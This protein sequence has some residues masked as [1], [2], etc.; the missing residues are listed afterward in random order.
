MKVTENKI[1][2]NKAELKEQLRIQKDSQD[3]LRRNIIKVD[4]MEKDENQAWENP[5]NKLTPFL[6]DRLKIIDELYIEREHRAGSRGVINAIG[7]EIPVTIVTRLSDY[8]D[9]EE[10]I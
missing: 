2:E 1:F 8:K 5:D 9:K 7:N 3:F 6:Y 10:I 4:G